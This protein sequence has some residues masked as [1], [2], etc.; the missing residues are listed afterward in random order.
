MLRKTTLAL[1]A[2]A[3]LLAAAAAPAGA[4]IPNNKI[5]LGVLTDLSGFASDSTGMG[6]VVAAR[7]AAEDFKK[8]KPG[9]DVEV[10]SQD[11]QN[12]P[13]IGSATAR[14]WVSEGQV[15]AI[16]DVPFSS[17]ALAVQE[18]VRGSKVAF[19]ASGPGTALLTGEKCSPNTVH[20][21]YDTWA[22]AHGTALALLKQKKDTWFFIT[23]DYAFGHALEA[24]A[25]A[26]VKAEGG[27]VLGQVRHPT[28]TS[29][30]SS[31]LVQAQ[32]SGAK[33]VALA[34]AVGDTINSVKQASEFG[35]TSGGQ[36]LAALLMQ[37]TDVHSVGLATAKGLFLTEGFY[38]NMNDGTRA[39]ADRFAAQMNGRRPTANQAGVYSGA[40]H[41]LRAAAAANSTDG[42]TVVAKMKEMPS[43]D[44][45]F[46]K[47]EVRA[48]GRHIHNMYLFQVKTP[49]ES[50][51][52]WDYYNLIETIPAKEA[53]RP[54]A[55]GNCPMVA[56]K[57]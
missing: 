38:W 56:A 54:L 10:I 29:D 41:Y 13:D 31:F 16:L 24:D 27:K 43:D 17:V 33:V 15:D 26:V 52:P 50:K 51:G 46:G 14:K 53:F 39:F 37:L 47:G 7:L 48:D 36:S 35:L 44:P 8:E 57:K 2:G 49:A 18:A 4:E 30:F 3:A 25:M 34:N 23:A 1:A 11:H 22:L 21:T 42:Q 5:R 9:L 6:S 45:L 19:I 55:E 28:N 12:K 20:W 40:L 32:A